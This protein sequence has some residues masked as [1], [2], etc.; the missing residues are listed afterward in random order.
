MG[1]EEENIGVYGMDS[2]DM[3]N[4]SQQQLVVKPI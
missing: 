4:D 2:D 1:Y 3:S